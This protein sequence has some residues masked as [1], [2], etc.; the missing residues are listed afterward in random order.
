M[1]GNKDEG[2]F[3]SVVSHRTFGVYNRMFSV[4]LTFGFRRMF[5]VPCRTFSVL[6][7][8]RFE[9]LGCATRHMVERLG[10]A[11]EHLVDYF[12]RTFG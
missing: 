2:L 11:V 5:S 9:R 6:T 8:T 1:T 7:D 10:C 3:F 4:L 12:N